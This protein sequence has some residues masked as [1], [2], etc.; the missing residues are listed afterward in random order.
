MQT[1]RND[2]VLKGIPSGKIYGQL[3]DYARSKGV[4]VYPETCESSYTVY[5]S[6]IFTSNEICG[7]SSKLSHTPITFEQFF[8]Y[9]DNW[10]KCQPVTVKLND[11]YTAKIEGN[12]V[13]EGARLLNLKRLNGCIML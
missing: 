11:E 12:T 5:P 13:K 3:V 10:S 8:Q 6:L 1:F 9:C 4:P 7:I 2:Y